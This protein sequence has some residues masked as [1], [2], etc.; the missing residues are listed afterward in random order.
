VLVQKQLADVGIEMKLQAVPLK[1]IAGRAATGEFDAFIFEMAGRSLSWV[2]QFWRSGGGINNSGYT[3]ADVTLDKIRRA[4]S[5]DETREYVAELERIM[6]AD[7]PAAFLTW[8]ETARAVSTKFDVAPEENRDI[9]ASLWQW[10]PAR[11]ASK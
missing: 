4:R 1:Q 7:P 11:Q 3:A 2:Y 8:Q 9:M 5:E 6:H 10:R